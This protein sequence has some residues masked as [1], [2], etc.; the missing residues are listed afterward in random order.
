MKNSPHCLLL[1]VVLPA[2]SLLTTQLHAQNWAISAG[3][4]ESY[5]GDQHTSPLLYQSDALHLGG[6]YNFS[7]E[8]RFEI[9]LQIQ[10]GTNQAQRHRRREGTFYEIPSSVE[11]LERLRFNKSDAPLSTELKDRIV[12]DGQSIYELTT[13]ITLQDLQAY[14]YTY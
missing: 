14:P 5:I 1:L 4:T 7:G 3:W 9:G 6:Q 2:I 8:S 12:M 13:P 10:I 11:T